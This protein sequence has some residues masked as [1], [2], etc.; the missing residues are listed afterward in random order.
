MVELL[1][2]HVAINET[3]SEVEMKLDWS[4]R[5]G[6]SK[7]K[8]LPAILGYLMLLLSGYKILKDIKK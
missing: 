5:K 2:K 6:E 8:L 3:I 7:M 4:L 1:L